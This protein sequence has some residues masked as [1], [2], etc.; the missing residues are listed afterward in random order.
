MAKVRF[1][2]GAPDAYEEGVIYFDPATK[3]IK[4]L[5]TGSSSTE[6]YDS[7]Y[8]ATPDYKSG[9]R[10]PA[11]YEFIITIEGGMSKNSAT[12]YVTKYKGG[13]NAGSWYSKTFAAG[14]SVPE[15]RLVVTTEDFDQLR[16]TL[17]GSSSRTQVYAPGSGS[18]VITYAGGEG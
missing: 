2:E 17:A 10:I 15:L 16:T 11:G 5:S 4:K 12:Q 9:S 13:T 18:E 1:A 6:V 3:T 14:A 8:V 7:G